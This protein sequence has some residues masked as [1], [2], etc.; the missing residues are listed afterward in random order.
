MSLPNDTMDAKIPIFLFTYNLGRFPTNYDEVSDKLLEVLPEEPSS[1]YVFG[2]QEFCSI[3][4]GCFPDTANHSLL[5]INKVVIDT[6]KRKYGGAE[7]I[8]F[9]TISIH[10]SGA[11]GQ[12]LITPYI[13]RFHQVQT[14]IVGC[15]YYGSTM[16]GAVGVRV[17]YTDPQQPEDVELTFALCH[18]A[19]GE[20]EYYYLKRNRNVVNIMRAL[21]FD[22][23]WSFLKPNAHSFIMGDMNYRTC[24]KFDR[25]SDI[26]AQLFSLHDQTELSQQQ[27]NIEELFTAHDELTKGRNDQE[28]LLGFDEGEVRFSPTYK[29][30]RGT[31]IYNSKR[32]PS[33]CDRIFYQS[34]YKVQSIQRVAWDAKQQASPVLQDS[35]V[36]QPIVRKYDSVPVL[37]SD[38]QP[39]YL[40]I[41]IPIEPPKSIISA[42]TGYLQIV[43]NEIRNIHDFNNTLS[44][45]GPTQ[46]YMKYTKV[47]YVLQ[48]VVRPV[49]DSVIGYGLWFSTTTRGRLQLF[50]VI[51]IM[52]LS[53]YIATY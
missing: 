9:Y 2:F 45:S 28:V 18:L 46:I 38:H 50:V 47:D 37:E 40:D 51:V 1:L 25:Q 15:G 42:T 7:D 33:W 8:K 5:Q 35:V 17:K 49:A 26:S 44:I 16:K 19:A 20:G 4:A 29:F 10:H 11:V 48:V 27:S 30:N 23:G 3:L 41:L 53:Y 34:T 52:A 14:S 36:G 43:P 31:A 32:S 22:D 39:V 24:K 6:L 21:V 12:I 13:L